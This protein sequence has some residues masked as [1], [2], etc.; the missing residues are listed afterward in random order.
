MFS[1]KCI[2]QG[3]YC[4]NLAIR[5]NSIFVSKS[6]VGE[7]ILKTVPSYFSKDLVA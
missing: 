7:T 5:V 4:N 3:N 1:D 6:S 2:R